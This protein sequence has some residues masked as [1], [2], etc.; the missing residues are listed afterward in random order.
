M[1]ILL[2]C[3]SCHPQGG[4]AKAT[5][6]RT[7][8]PFDWETS[9]GLLLDA[10]ITPVYERSTSRP[11]RAPVGLLR[12]TLDSNYR[13]IISAITVYCACGNVFK[14]RST[15]GS[16][17]YIDVCAE[18]HPAYTGQQRSTVSSGRIDSFNRPYSTRV[19][20]SEVRS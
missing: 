7:V 10:A 18:D 19:V 5:R 12:Y 11:S 1:A 3:E 9:L 15:R 13:V 8:S 16:S 14:T 6:R 2:L 4:I 17:L 20:R